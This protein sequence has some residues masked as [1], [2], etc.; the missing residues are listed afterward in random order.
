MMS[1]AFPNF[2]IGSYE[3]SLKWIGYVHRRRAGEMAVEQVTVRLF[4]GMVEDAN[5]SYWDEEWSVKTWGAVVAPPALLQ[6]WAIP[7]PWKPGGADIH[8]ALATQVPLPGRSL[9][10]VSTDVTYERHARVGETVYVEER[11]TAIS[12]AKTARVGTG[13]FVTTQATYSGVD[14]DVIAICTNILFRFE[15]EG[16]R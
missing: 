12:P 3:D 5:R 7:L 6:T 16:E 13:H 4:A 11:V 14:R 10:N 2:P 15:P 8:I 9:I 1:D